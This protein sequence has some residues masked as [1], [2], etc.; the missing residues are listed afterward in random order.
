MFR[1]T[2]GLFDQAE[3]ATLGLTSIVGD[4]PNL[5]LAVDNDYK[6]CHHPSLTVF[7]DRLYCCWS[8]GVTGEDEPGQRVLLSSSLDGRLWSEPT[9]VVRPE[10]DNSA[11]VASGFHVTEDT[12]VCYYST[13]YGDNFHEDVHLSAVASSDGVEWGDPTRITSGF[14]IEGPR[15]LANGRLL[16]GGEHVGDKRTTAGLRMRLLYSDHPDGLTGWQEAS[17]SPQ[18]SDDFQYTEPNMAVR[19]DG[20]PVVG[21]RSQ[22]GYL[23][24]STTGDNGTTWST[25]QMT[26]FPD[27]TSRFFLRT[28]ANGQTILI[29]N[30]GATQYDRS[31]LALSTSDDGIT[32]YRSVALRNEPATQDFGGKHKVDGWQYPNALVWNDSLYVAYSINKEDIAVTRVS[33][34]NLKTVSA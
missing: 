15:K 10:A 20:V 17:V 28:L 14:F 31:V 4:H 25:P 7:R 22:T 34:A 6:F 1:I 9:V 33:M 24:A 11:H 26:K 13:T 27:S 12:L 29:N 32:F 5:Y 2:E 8:N 3:P 16:L 23:F 30:P 21:F 19:P 18:A